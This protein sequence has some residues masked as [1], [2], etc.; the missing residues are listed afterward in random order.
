MQGRPSMCVFRAVMMNMRE[1]TFQDFRTHCIYL[2]M[3]LLPMGG[4]SYDG[5]YPIHRRRNTK[6]ATQLPGHPA[7]KVFTSIQPLDM[8]G[9]WGMQRQQELQLIAV[10]TSPVST[11]CFGYAGHKSFQ[12]FS[13]KKLFGSLD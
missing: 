8:M 5:I 6:L 10:L 11:L 2:P 7:F 9:D 12:Q 13:A 3:F 4:S 1:I